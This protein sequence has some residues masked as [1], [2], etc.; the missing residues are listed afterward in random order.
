MTAMKFTSLNKTEQKAFNIRDFSGGADYADKR[1]LKDGKPLSEA[2]NMY[3]KDGRLTSRPGISSNSGNAIINPNCTTDEYRT[4]H[5][6][7]CTVTV[8]GSENKIAYFQLCEAD[9]H[10]YIYIFL[11]DASGVSSPAGYLLFN[12]VTSENF[13][14]PRNILFFTGKPVNGGGVF[15]LITRYDLYNTSDK[16]TDMY[17]IS[18]DR[19]EWN[20]INNFYIPVV[21]INGRGNRYEEATASK[22]AYTDQP[23]ALESMNMLTNYFKAYYTSDGHSSSFKL[24]FSNLSDNTVKCRVYISASQYTEWLVTGTSSTQKLYNADITLNIDREKGII[25]FTGADNSDYPV[26]MMNLY[27][28]NNICVTAEKKADT[29]TKHNTVWTACTGSGSKFIVSG[30]SGSQIFSVSY[31]NPLYFPRNSSVNVGE[32]DQEIK[33]LLPYKGGVLVYKKSGVYSVYVKN[34]AVINTNALLADDDTQF[35]RRDTFTVKKVNCNIGGKNPNVCTLFEGSPVWLGTDNVIYRLNTSTF[36][37]EALS[38]A[39]TP[40]LN[41]ANIYYGYSFAVVYGKYYM[42]FMEEK[43]VIMEYN[44]KGEPCWYYW[45]FGNIKVK[46]AAVSEGKLLLFCVGSDNQ[47]FY[48]ARLSGNTDTDM[49]YVGTDITASQ[50]SFTSRFTTAH[51]DFG[52]IASKKLI[53]SVTASLSSNGYADIYINGKSLD[54]LRLSGKSSDCGCGALNT[55][56]IIPHIYGANEFYLTAESD[57]GLTAGEITVSYKTVK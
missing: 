33:A 7:D 42:L 47:V 18:A 3:C 28:E 32:N 54:R 45:D 10:C 25:Y 27:H 19:T 31:D 4:Y 50:K 35:Y 51:L 17:E 23:A 29:D 44:A 20:S 49:R 13:Y 26:P 55:V 41:N 9:A 43:A 56:K 57:E 8:D 36:K 52:S 38:E 12:R 22:L 30:G 21:S 24:P 14:V 39:V 5:V 34:G 1:S 6:T 16:I 15:A 11:I 37:A 53:G 46:G 2:L 48:T 40:L